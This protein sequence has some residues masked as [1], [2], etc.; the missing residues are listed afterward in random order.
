M[1]A[2]RQRVTPTAALVLR[3]D[4]PREQWLTA[5]RELIGSSDVADIVGVGYNSARHVYYQKRGDLPLDEEIGEAALWGNLHEETVAREWARRN[6]SAVQRVG[7]VANLER[8]WMGATL[9]RR[10]PAGLCP[11]DRN[12]P[13]EVDGNRYPLASRGAR[14]CLEVKTRNAYVAGKW[15]RG[16]PDDVHAQALWQ[17]M[18]TGLDHVHVACLIGGSDF[19]QYTVRANEDLERRLLSAVELF[20]VDLARGVPPPIQEEVDPDRYMELEARLHPNREGTAHLGDKDALE[21][22]ELMRSYRM[23]HKV[24]DAHERS[25]KR[26]RNRLVELLG[27]RDSAVVDNELIYTYDEQNQAPSVDLAALAE[28]FPEAYAACVTPKKGR[29]LLIKWKGE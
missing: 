22:F 14:C 9:D 16:V 10:V 21:A 19:R 11:L 12:P 20:R 23:S 2:P 6:H 17:R 4:A 15:L 26:D 8:P 24:A 1:T 3:A 18:V 13:P 5:R 7:L 25:K 29:R 28:R 27:G